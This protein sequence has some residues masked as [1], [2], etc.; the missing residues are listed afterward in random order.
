M[1]VAAANGTLHLQRVPALWQDRVRDYVV[2]VDG[3]EAG[4]IANDATLALPLAAGEHRVRLAIDWCRSPEVR[5]NV[6][7]DG[8]VAM[9]CGP[10]ANPLLVLLYI[11]VWRDR[12]LW[13][14]HD[15]A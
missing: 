7:A 11:S 13:L 9:A 3:E 5:I 12:Y 10:N 14:R 8:T 15:A 1:S 2:L 6:P 4:R